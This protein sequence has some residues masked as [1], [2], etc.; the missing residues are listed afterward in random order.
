MKIV[1]KTS[2]LL[3][4]DLEK[5][6]LFLAHNYQQQY[7]KYNQSL[8]YILTIEQVLFKINFWAFLFSSFWSKK[9]EKEGKKLFSVLFK[10][11]FNKKNSGIKHFYNSLG[12]ILA[13][14]S[15]FLEL[16]EI[17]CKKLVKTALK[18]LWNMLFTI[19]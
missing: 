8:L 18:M 19:I 5:I 11:I 9:K 16:L 1:G 2:F 10:G 15:H 3:N 7:L 12:V 17:N 4:K 6:T 13:H 14:F